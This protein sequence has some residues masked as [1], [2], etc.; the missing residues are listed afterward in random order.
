MRNSLKEGLRR[1][2]PQLFKILQ[3]TKQFSYSLLVQNQKRSLKKKIEQYYAGDSEAQPVL[4][5]LREN[6]LEMIPY[7]YIKEYEKTELSVINDIALRL[8]YVVVKG[9]KIYFPEAMSDQLIIES[10]R[11]A[12]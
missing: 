7:S 12:M 9:N 6:P 2:L 3:R 5:F 11:I 8:K 10:V 4:S 1:K